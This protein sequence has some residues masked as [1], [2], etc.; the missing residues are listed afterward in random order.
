LS[1]SLIFI[2]YTLKPVPGL[3]DEFLPDIQPNGNCKTSEAIER[4]IAEKRAQFRIE[5]QGYPYWATFDTVCLA[6]PSIEKHVI[7]R[8]ENRAPGNPEGKPTVSAAVGNWLL[9]HFPDAWHNTPYAMRGAPEAAFVGF[10]PG[11]FLKILGL[12]CTL[13]VH[14]TEPLPLSLWYGNSDHRDVTSA[15]M[16]SGFKGLDWKIVLGRRRPLEPEDAAKWDELFTGWTGPGRDANKDLDAAVLLATQIG[17][18]TPEGVVSEAA[19]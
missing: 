3:G 6:A 14:N 10:D 12:E 7:Y 11:T 9:T 17:F 4:S 18:L 15:V 8:S 1:P 2:G 13:P 16:P 19:A 5:S